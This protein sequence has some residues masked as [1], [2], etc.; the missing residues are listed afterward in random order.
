MNDKEIRAYYDIL[1]AAWRF[2][3]KH[4]NMDGSTEAYRLMYEDGKRQASEFTSDGQLAHDL[5]VTMCKAVQRYDLGRRGK[6]DR[7]KG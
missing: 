2:F 7:N 6:L 5:F 1:T 4:I 3:K